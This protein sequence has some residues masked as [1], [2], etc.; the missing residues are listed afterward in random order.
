MKFIFAEKGTEYFSY[1]LHALLIN[2]GFYEFKSHF[3]VLY[4]QNNYFALKHFS[5]L[6]SFKIN[7]I[8]YECIRGMQRKL[9]YK[10]Q[11]ILQ[12]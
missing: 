10:I 3:L 5:F 1:Y 6:E 7:T 11:S 4:F 8:K 2:I 9:L 12:P